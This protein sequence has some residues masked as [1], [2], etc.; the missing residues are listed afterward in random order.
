MDQTKIAQLVDLLKRHGIKA[1]FQP[2]TAEARQT[3]FA[4]AEPG[5]TV[6]IGGSQTIAALE[7]NQ[8]LAEKG[9]RVLDHN[10]APSRDES[11]AMRHEQLH[12]DLFLCST[13]ALTEKGQLVNVDGVGNRVG[14]MAFGPKKVVVVAGMNKI[15]PDLDAAFERI[16]TV[17]APKNA[18]RLKRK[19]PCA[20][21]GRCMDCSSPERMC[22][23]F[24]IIERRPSLTDLEVIVV[25]EELG[26]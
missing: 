24:T 17:A 16:R 11:T 1:S 7:L 21:V 23:V 18:Q 6:G 19:T 22:S 8:A 20:E 5:Q 12:C 25:G 13:N 15:V 2:T 26:Y 10:R 14:A 3:V 9:C 4:M